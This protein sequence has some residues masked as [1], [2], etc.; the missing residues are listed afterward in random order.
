MTFSCPELSLDEVIELAEKLGYDSFEPR[1]GSGHK[2]GVE[3][4]ADQ[5]TRKQIKEKVVAS[6][7]EL[8]CLATSCNYSN[9][10]TCAQMVKDTLAAI[11]LASDVGCKRLRVFGGPIPEGISREQAIDA[12]AEALKSVAPLAEEKNVAVCLETHDD[13]CNPE[14][15]AAVIKKVDSP[16]IAVNWDIMHPV[17]TA[18]KTMDS[19]FETL[20]PWIKH[21]HIHDGVWVGEDKSLSL[22]PIGQGMVDHKRA[23]ELLSQMG[24]EDAL[25]GEWINW[26]G[27]P[28]EQHLPHELATL[29]EIESSLNK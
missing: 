1:I 21:C 8:S 27:F 4:D 18:E 3:T 28:Y 16:A 22:K 23:I 19:A 26:A 10:E 13:W 17:R 29:K 5:E 12:V 20:K 25:S 6:K 2:H 14:H 24:Y 15:V 7:I 9:P 11:E